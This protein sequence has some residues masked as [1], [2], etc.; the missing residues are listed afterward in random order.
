MGWGSS[1]ASLPDPP[2]NGGGAGGGRRAHKHRSGAARALRSP[3]PRTPQAP[4]AAHLWGPARTHARART[5]LQTA[6]VAGARAEEGART[7]QGRQSQRWRGNHPRM[8]T[9]TP[10]QGRARI[11]GKGEHRNK[12]G[13]PQTPEERPLALQTRQLTPG[14]GCH[15]RARRRAHKS[16]LLPLRTPEEHR[17]KGTHPLGQG[18]PHP[19]SARALGET[20]GHAHTHTHHTPTEGGVERPDARASQLR[21]DAQTLP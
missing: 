4:C 1:S 11:P 16:P 19:L 14:R 9:T 21:R 5:P 20:R 10:S 17:T 6:A 18:R 13:Q 7:P 12:A 15:P 8:R 3:T 2:R